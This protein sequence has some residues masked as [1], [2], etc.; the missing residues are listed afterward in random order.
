MPLSFRLSESV[1]EADV[2]N[3]ERVWGFL[4]FAEYGVICDGH[5]V[6]VKA[7]ARVIKDR[8]SATSENFL[9]HLVATPGGFLEQSGG[10]SILK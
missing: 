1:S 5:N 3:C 2:N 8:K 9:W 4:V 7:T 10:W 6:F